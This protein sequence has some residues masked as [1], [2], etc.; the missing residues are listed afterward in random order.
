MLLLAIILSSLLMHGRTSVGDE[1]PDICHNLTLKLNSS[2]GSKLHAEFIQSL[3]LRCVS[4]AN[5]GIE[6]AELNAFDGIPNLMYLN[7]EGNL[8]AP[9]D[10]FSYGSL[11]N[12][13]ILLMNDQIVRPT[14]G[15][16]M[17]NYMFDPLE[18]LNLSNNLGYYPITGI[19][20]NISYPFR[21]LKHLDLSGNRLTSFDP[22]QLWNGTL[23]HLRINDNK[24]SRVRLNESSN[25]KSLTLDNNKLRGIGRDSLDLTGLK[26]LQQLSVMNNEINY[27]DRLAFN[28]TVKLR[29]L[30]LSK[31][32]LA[33][34]YPET[35][36]NLT[37]LEVAI[38][39][40]NM[41]DTIP[42]KTPLNLTVLSMDCNNIMCL[43][44]YSFVNLIYLKKLSLAGNVISCIA[45]DTFQS[46]E[47]LEELYLNDNQLNYL[48]E[49]WGRYL[50]SLRYMNLSGN[51]LTIIN[52]MFDTPNMPLEALYLDG[53]PLKYIKPNA[54]KV[55]PQNVTIYL[56]IG[57]PR[58]NNFCGVYRTPQNSM[59][60][61]D[62][63]P[64]NP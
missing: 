32:T 31:N 19:S 24:L 36:V 41:L 10:M 2:V 30:N 18:Y 56:N 1:F 6:Y 35:F 45:T 28:D 55:V 49:Y 64:I 15:V 59:L 57:E 5:S 25:L 40:Y 54:L 8:I 39:D 13:R 50:K 12:I 27:I 20:S 37:S 52:Y 23:T 29:Y 62:V 21:T 63:T 51:K 47:M 61:N 53:N 33:T 26:S 43:S 9:S 38:L 22:I 34:I 58:P 7:L 16:L 3:D 46:Q 44:A 11:P 60:T 48:P 4:I 17:I 42:F 14:S